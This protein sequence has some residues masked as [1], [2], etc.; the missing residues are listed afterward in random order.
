MR[1]LFG[2]RWQR[3][4]WGK[5][6]TTSWFSDR[7]EILNFIIYHSKLKSIDGGINTFS[8]G[9]N[10]SLLQGG[11]VLLQTTHFKTVILFKETVD[12]P[13]PIFSEFFLF[14][15]KPSIA[16][17]TTVS[18][19]NIKATTSY[20]LKRIFELSVNQPKVSFAAKHPGPWNSVA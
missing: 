6:N 10:Q 20:L 14:H 15:I 5:Y 9:S 12:L 1:D 4:N 11:P 8:R 16:I 7:H 18:K 2:M 3:L 17:L 13:G 19:K